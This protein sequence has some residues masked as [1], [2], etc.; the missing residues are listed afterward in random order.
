MLV[1]RCLTA[2]ETYKSQRLN[3]RILDFTNMFIED[4]L[5]ANEEV[6]FDTRLSLENSVRE[7]NDE[8]IFAQWQKFTKAGTKDEASVEVK[9]LLSLL[10]KKIEQ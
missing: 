4:V 7:L 2:M 6:S 3:A 5:M 1:Y 8:E 10:I 9:V